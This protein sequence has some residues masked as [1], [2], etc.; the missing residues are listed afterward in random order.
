[1]SDAISH[2]FF[3]NFQI[4]NKIREI[5]VKGICYLLII[6]YNFLFF[7]KVIFSL[8]LFFS[9]G[10]GLIVCQNFLLSVIF[11]L[12]RFAKYSLFTF[13]RSDTQKFFCFVFLNLF[14]TVGF[15]KK[16]FLKY[17]LSIMDLDNTLAMKGLLFPRMYFFFLGA[18]C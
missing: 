18:W 12:L 14:A 1:M 6:S 8:D 9:V 5:V 17:V 3:W 4:F 7:T 11:F 15:F 10:K 2:K 13:L 16:V